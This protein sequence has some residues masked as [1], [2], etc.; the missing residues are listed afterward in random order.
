MN[1]ITIAGRLGSDPETRFTSGGQKVTSFR[2]ASNTRKSGK[3]DTIWYRITVWG[4]Q[5]DRMMPYLKKGSAVII[6]GD[7]SK[8]EIYTNREGQS[9]VSLDV[10][11]SQINFSPF[12]G[13][14][15]GEKTGGGQQQ[16]GGQSHEMASVQS[17][18]GMG[19]EP[20][21]FSEDE[22]PF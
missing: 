4:E 22:I 8:P 10:T 21:P 14:S 9:Q 13:K 18:Q 17:A 11:A 6:H 15:D 20:P 5:F 12:G 1:H 2:M 16:M 19:S 7:L 3:D